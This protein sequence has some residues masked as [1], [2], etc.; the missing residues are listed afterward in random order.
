[1]TQTNGLN[2]A[3]TSEGWQLEIDEPAELDRDNYAGAKYQIR[4]HGSPAVFELRW[5]WVPMFEWQPPEERDESVRNYKDFHWT[6]PHLVR[7]FSS[8]DEAMRFAEEQEKY[9]LEPTNA[10]PPGV[11]TGLWYRFQSDVDG[12]RYLI[13]DDIS[14]D[15]T[16]WKLEVINS[17]LGTRSIEKF[18]REI[19]WYG[20]HPWSALCDWGEYIVRWIPPGDD[21]LQP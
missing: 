14:V 2:W 20:E 3:Q 12:V 16:G 6:N 19:S 8:L 7:D 10:E 21:C 13:V 4:Q 17:S 15:M 1:M 18:D 5:M 9:R 11:L